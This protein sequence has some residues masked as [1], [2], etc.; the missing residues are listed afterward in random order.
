[1]KPFFGVV[2]A[3]KY[4]DSIFLTEPR[5]CAST[6]F[7]VSQTEPNTLIHSSFLRFL[8]SLMFYIPKLTAI[9]E[10][11][12]NLMPP[13]FFAVVSDGWSEGSAYYLFVFAAFPVRNLSCFDRAILTIEPRRG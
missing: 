6:A 2:V 5:Y 4:P 8:A 7:F 13:E 1:M 9:V 3:I 12:I 11:Q 10:K